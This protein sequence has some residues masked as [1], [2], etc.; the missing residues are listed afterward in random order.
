MRDSL[1][2]AVS[3]LVVVWAAGG[4]VAAATYDVI[5]DRW[6]D[7]IARQPMFFVGTAPLDGGGHVNVSP[8][9]PIGSLQVVDDRTVAYL[10]VARN[11]HAGN[12]DNG[13]RKSNRDR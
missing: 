3:L 6:R 13:P 1:R 2:L 8:K 9:G 10:D 5:D 7:W 12:Q 4:D 11:P